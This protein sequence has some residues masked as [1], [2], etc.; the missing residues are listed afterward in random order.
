MKDT[1]LNHNTDKLLLFLLVLATGYIV[2]HIIHHGTADQGAL[3]WAENAFSTVLGALILILTGRVNRTDGQTA[4]GVPP[5][6][7][8]TPQAPVAAQSW[9]KP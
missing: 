7:P 9:T 6:I 8:S 2:M 4:N 5:T 1:W 3:E